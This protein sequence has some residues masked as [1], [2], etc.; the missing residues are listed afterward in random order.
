[1]KSSRTNLKTAQLCEFITDAFFCSA[2]NQNTTRG[3]IKMLFDLGRKEKE[4][5]A[6]KEITV[7][8]A[9]CPQNHKCPSLRV[10]PTE[11][12]TQ[13]GFSAPEV[14]HGKCISCGKC[15]RYCPMGAIALR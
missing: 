10:C 15:V 11:A 9:R 1:M 6:S 4:N 14:D 13:K 3:T 7:I 8:K 2:Y 12:L 5:G